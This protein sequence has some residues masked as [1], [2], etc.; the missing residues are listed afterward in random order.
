MRKIGKHIDKKIMQYQ[1]IK[2]NWV[3]ELIDPENTIK[4]RVNIKEFKDSILD[5]LVDGIN[6]KGYEPERYEVKNDK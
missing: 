4:R 2:D 1:M 6:R 3:L 5:D